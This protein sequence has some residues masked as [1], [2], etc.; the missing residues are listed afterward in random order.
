MKKKLLKDVFG[1][2]SFRDFQEEIVDSILGG[3][4]SIAVLPT[5]GGKSLCYQLPTLLLDGLTVVIS[6]LI[7][8]MQDQVKALNE[9][10][11]SACMINSMQSL[12]ENSAVFREVKSKNVKF[13][14]I[15]PERL[16]SGDFIEFLKGL[17][18]NYF[19]I[20]EA[21]CVSAWGHEFRADYLSLSLLKENFPNTPVVAFTAT[22]TLKVQED[23]CHSLRLKNPQVFRAKTKRDNLIIEVHKRNKN[24]VNQILNFL[25][26]HKNQC[27]IIYTFTR[28]EAEKLALFLQSHGHSAMSYHAGLDVQQRQ[29]VYE[30]FAYE[31]IDIVVATIAFGMGIDK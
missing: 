12:E 10:K 17:Q 19:V 27:G 25:R 16:A 24:G 3:N 18:V 22:A 20:D 4:D 8:L 6:P 7:A 11:L 2:D 9:L 14:Y 28:K 26:N 29:K 15:A 31:K 5:G 21:H 13:L 30:Y 1:F 23:I